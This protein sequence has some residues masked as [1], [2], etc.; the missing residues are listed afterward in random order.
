V[1]SGDPITGIED[2]EALPGVHVL[3][4]GTAL[5]LNSAADDDDAIDGAHLVSAGGRVLSVVGVGPNLTAAR[6][7]AYAG[8]DEIELPFGHHRNDIAA[9][10]TDGTSV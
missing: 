10:A 8:V 4:A 2:A 1:R 7:A 6:A 9:S 3:H 5:Q